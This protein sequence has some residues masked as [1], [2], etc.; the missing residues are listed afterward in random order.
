MRERW[1]GAARRFAHRREALHQQ[2]DDVFL[3]RLLLIGQLLFHACVEFVFLADHAKSSSRCSI[4]DVQKTSPN[5]RTRERVATNIFRQVRL[6]S[7]ALSSRSRRT[8]AAR[9]PSRDG[10]RVVDGQEFNIEDQLGF[11][12]TLRDIFSVRELVRTNRR[13]CRRPSCFETDSHPENQLAT[14]L[15]ELERLVAVERRIEFLP[16]RITC[17][18]TVYCLPGAA[19][20]PEPTRCRPVHRQIWTGFR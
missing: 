4:G 13:R 11:G 16:S 5:D 9:R 15:N 1:Y 8:K 3:A 10:G 2:L 19:A 18:V 6:A 17:V 12:G 20:A 14:A 7:G